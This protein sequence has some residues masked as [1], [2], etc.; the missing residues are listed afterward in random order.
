ME[1][2]FL[3]FSELSSCFDREWSSR[4]HQHRLCNQ[5][6]PPGYGLYNYMLGVPAPP[7]S[8]PTSTRPSP[9]SLDIA[10]PLLYTF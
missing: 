3:L 6:S 9:T 8:S 2:C 5:T 10:S 7:T 4:Q 1:L